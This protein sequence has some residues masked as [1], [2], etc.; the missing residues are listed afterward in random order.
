MKLLTCLFAILATYPALA[1]DSQFTVLSGSRP[2]AFDSMLDSLAKSDV[3]FIGE[4]HDHAQGHALE[5]AILKGLADRKANIALAMEMFERDVQ[6]VLDEYLHGFISESSFTAASRPWP[7]YKT[8]YRPMVELCK[9]RKIPVIASNAPRRYVSMVS[10]G[11]QES[12]AV[13][14]RDSRR[15]LAA[16]PYSTDVPAEYDRQLTAIFESQHAG[17]GTG[18]AQQPAMPSVANMKQAQELWDAT[19]A[20]SIVRNLKNG[21]LIVHV[22]GSM[23][24]DSGFGIAARLRAARPHARVM[25]VTIRPSAGYPE[26]PKDLPQSAADYCIITPEAPKKP[27]GAQ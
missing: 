20:D 19:M 10:R 14:P 11:G 26:P 5:L 25:I 24:S 7:A 15:H 3:V 22:N 12:L 27:G 4:Q 23:H 13:L 1:Q 6:P 16:L 8:D 17:A 2:I 9:E 21:R 18:S